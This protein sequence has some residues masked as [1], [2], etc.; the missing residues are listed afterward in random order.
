MCYTKH[1]QDK[2]CVVD[3]VIIVMGYKIVNKNLWSLLIWLIDVTTLFIVF[4]AML[5]YVAQMI[6]HLGQ[7]N[8]I[9]AD[10]MDGP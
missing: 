9:S 6:W 7:T 10:Q 5:K 1:N 4:K 2:W 8:T 3:V